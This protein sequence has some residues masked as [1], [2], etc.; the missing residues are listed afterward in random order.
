MHTTNTH[1]MHAYHMHTI[2]NYIYT[3]KKAFKLYTC[4]V[5]TT[6]FI[7]IHN[8][9]RLYTI[10]KHIRHSACILYATTCIL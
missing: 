9:Y 4:I 8:T 6:A 3:T 10:R 2:C 5:Y 7:Y 1:V